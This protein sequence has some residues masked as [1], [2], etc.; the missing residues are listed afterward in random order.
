MRLVIQSVENDS[1]SYQPHERAVRKRV[2]TILKG[3]QYAHDPK[4]R[5]DRM[6]LAS[7]WVIDV[8]GI[9]GLMKLSLELD[10]SLIFE[11]ETFLPNLGT[12]AHP[13]V[14]IYDGY[15]E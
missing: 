15:N 12:I 7:M 13:G 8:D 6:I 10:K 3:E 11:H 1:R 9:E 5:Q 14:R 2:R 4:N